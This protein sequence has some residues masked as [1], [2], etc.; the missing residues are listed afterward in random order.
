MLSWTMA[1]RQSDG[2]GICEAFDGKSTVKSG[3]YSNIQM[4]VLQQDQ[5]C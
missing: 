5:Q 3:I 2:E 1:F 4:W